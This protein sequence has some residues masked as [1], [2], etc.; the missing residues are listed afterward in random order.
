MPALA[1]A[2][3]WRGIASC[4][5]GHLHA[6]HVGG[7]AGALRGRPSRG[8]RRRPVREPAWALRDVARTAAAAGVPLVALA[9]GRRLAWPGLALDV[10]GPPH[11]AA[12]VDPDDGT[13][14]NDRS[15]VVRA[16]TQRAPCCWRATRSSLS[17]PIC[18]PPGSR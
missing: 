15:L 7:I 12:L 4:C 8:G 17:R 5:S 11:P 10:L 1:R 14:V 18:S 2:S 16:T 3:V 13:A 9:A 6:D